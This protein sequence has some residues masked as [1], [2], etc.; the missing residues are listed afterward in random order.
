MQRQLGFVLVRL[1]HT[2]AL[3]AI[4]QTAPAAIG[5]EHLWVTAPQGVNPISPRRRRRWVRPGGRVLQN[6]IAGPACS[7]AVLHSEVATERVA[8]ARGRARLPQAG[9]RAGES[10]WGAAL[11]SPVARPDGTPRRVSQGR[12]ASAG[13]R[14]ARGGRTSGG[15]SPW[16]ARAR[17]RS[18]RRTRL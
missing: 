12:G 14:S 10:G 13:R 5:V 1:R 3:G 7:G 8:A 2:R 4:A 15:T 11:R 6:H 17:A 9:S 18:G 16:R